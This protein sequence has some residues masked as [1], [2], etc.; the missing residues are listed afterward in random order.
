GSV[1]PE[2][3]GSSPVEPAI[4]SDS[5][6]AAD[7]IAAVTLPNTLPMADKKGWPFYEFLVE[8]PLYI[9]AA[10]SEKLSGDDRPRL[11]LPK[12]IR[13]YCPIEPCSAVLDWNL[14]GPSGYNEYA[15]LGSV[16]HRAYKCR[17][18]G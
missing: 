14:D 6:E 10:L 8:A 9:N 12:T 5:C 11:Y 16:H 2:V 4:F 13:R 17:N 7:S 1:N 18:C 15:T 3:A